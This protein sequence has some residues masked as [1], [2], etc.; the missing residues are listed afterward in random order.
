MKVSLSWLKELVNIKLTPEE[1]AEIL[2]LTSIGVKETTPDYL[3]L[4]LTYNRGDLLSL[5]GVAREIAAVTGSKVLF[6][7][8]SLTYGSLPST[9]VEIEDE[10]L[11]PV[12]AVAKITGLKVGPSNPE[13]TKKLNDSGIRSVNNLV[14]IT[15][16]IM[17]EFGQPLHS[18]D[19]EAVEN[20]TIIVRRAKAGEA[21]TTLDGK[22]RKL[23][24]ED[25]VLADTQKPLDVAGIMGGKDTEVEDSTTTILL[26]A[27][28][29]NP[30][31]VRRTSKRLGLSSEASKRFEHGLTKTNLLQ[32]FAQAI[33]M[34]E[35]LGGKL[36]A[37]NLV[38]DL[39]DKPRSITL[40]QEKLN[41][42]LG[43]E[44]PAKQVES[45]LTSLG[46]HPKGAPSNSWQVTLPYF[47][48]DISLEEDVIEEVARMYGYE[49]IEG[50]S[51]KDEKIPEI[52]QSFY[53]FLYDLKVDLKDTGLTEVQTYSFYSTQVLDNFD[54]DK[55]NLIKIANPISVET[56]YLREDL[57][58]NLIDVAAKNIRQGFS[59]IAIFEIGKVYGPNKDHPSEDYRLSIVLMN[60]SDNPILELYQIFQQAMSH[61]RGEK[62][63]LHLGGGDRGEYEKKYFHPKRFSFLE[64]NGQ[65]VGGLAEVHKRYTDNFGIKG[66]VA[67]L[68]CELK[69]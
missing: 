63:Q 56:E 32:A 36:I 40:T 65:S 5:R 50:Q 53:N 9:T 62:L 25:I 10:K 20:K 58:P 66:R 41:N 35:S 3:E 68:E 19:A 14:D 15:N 23:T 69:P 16:L 13:W 49:K 34:Y 4:D 26:S 24:A 52:N 7:A 39:E 60:G 21:I 42:L 46:F 28:L 48:L 45:Y 1:L 12:E 22:I 61:L 6:T 54:W 64:E 2:S 55:K 8:D 11:S 27:S 67:V 51:L 30:V 17:L 44:I 37:I 31:M 59:D 18:F 33:K 38:G 29:F 47:R 57:W 43:V